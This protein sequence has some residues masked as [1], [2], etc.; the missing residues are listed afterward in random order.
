MKTTRRPGPAALLVPLALALLGGC[1]A[2]P[3]AAV[4]SEELR[5]F[6]SG[7]YVGGTG[8]S[9]KVDTDARDLDAAL[10]GQGFT[11]SSTLDEHD[12]AWK[13]FLGYRFDVPFGFE[14]GYVNLGQVSSTVDTLSVDPDVLLDALAATQPY[15]G[16][17]P[18]AAALFYLLDTKYVDGGL[19]GGVWYWK[20]DVEAETNAGDKVS[21]DEEGFDPFYGIFLLLDI[22]DRAQLRAEYERYV[23]D[24]DD[25]DF[26]SIG[27]QI[28]VN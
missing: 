23:L 26:L 8:G 7:W 14:L 10:A 13:A 16:E 1:Y 19:R 3:T 2:T 25:A 11:T 18:S 22:N 5:W 9:A 20:A 24:D 21:L 12:S 15:L 28:R 6:E 27:L 4:Q 17:G